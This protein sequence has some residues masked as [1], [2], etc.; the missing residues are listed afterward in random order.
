[1]KLHR[2]VI[3]WAG[4]Q[5]HGSAVTV[6]HFDG[7]EQPAPDVAAVLSAVF[8][9]K[10][11]MPTGVIATVPNTGDSIEDTTG[12]L[13]GVWAGSGGGPC[14][15]TGITNS[16]AGVGACVGWQTGGIVNG[17]RLRG[18]TFVVPLD[19][20]SY[21]ETGTLSASALGDVGG[22]AN[23]LQAV[24]GLA[25]WHRPTTVGG[26]DGTSYGVIS[27]RVRDKV[28]FLSSRRD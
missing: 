28:A 15:M 18:R 9:L 26:S 16:P 5:I 11:S 7:S 4:P 13:V 8:L 10:P 1:M 25:V 20:D 24:G 12:E 27:N 3:S 23:A 21:D 22:F 14:N 2:L 6:L 19:G 17:R